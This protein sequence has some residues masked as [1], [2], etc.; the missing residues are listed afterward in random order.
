MSLDI[1]N[2][3]EVRFQF[4]VPIVKAVSEDI[5][6][7]NGEIEKDARLLHG[8]AS[9]PS[10]DLQREIVVQK[11][12][13]FDELIKSGYVNWNH[14]AR[15]S[16]G[17]ILGR[18]VKAGFDADGN[19]VVTGK[20][21]KGI[22]A[23]DEAWELAQYLAQHPEENRRLGWSLEGRGVRKGNVVIRTRC[24]HIA[25]TNDPVQTD[26]WADIVKA[27][28]TGIDFDTTK[29]FTSTNASALLLE[30]L[31]SGQRG[32]LL[33][34]IMFGSVGSNTLAADIWT[35]DGKF[36]KGPIGLFKQ[37]V[38]KGIYHEDAEKIILKLRDA[39]LLSSRAAAKGA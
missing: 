24:R 35:P 11:G 39:G 26:S 29:S 9:T 7:E 18:P 15:T 34:E 6:G 37:F 22:R 14:T 33:N 10:Q 1:L 17:A 16:P 13:E 32:E 30:N 36:V 20:L 21:F 27:M 12:I 31:D 23:A 25:L 19:F 4:D 3:T 8:V 28:T 5:P 38:A 2:S